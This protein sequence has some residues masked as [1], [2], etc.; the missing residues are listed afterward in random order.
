M[1]YNER[2]VEKKDFSIFKIS[3]GAVLEIPFLSVNYFS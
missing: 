1:I 2:G 3:P